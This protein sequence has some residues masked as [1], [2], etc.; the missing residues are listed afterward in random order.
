MTLSAGIAW[1]GSS[2]SLAVGTD[3]VLY[4]V[5]VRP[6]YHYAACSKTIVYAYQSRTTQEHFLMFWDAAHNEQHCKPTMP[7]VSLVGH[8]QYTLVVTNGTAAGNFEVTI[9]NSIGSPVDSRSLPFEPSM[10]ALTDTHA[11]VCSGDVV[12]IWHFR[13]E[14]VRTGPAVHA[15]SCNVLGVLNVSRLT[16]L[17]ICF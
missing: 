9:F 14:A 4:L 17:F 3:S 10:A 13:S 8:G 5:S 2:A 12:F 15:E 6:S 16:V 7:V 11:I 1:D